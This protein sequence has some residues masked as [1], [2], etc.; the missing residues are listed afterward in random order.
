VHPQRA[1]EERRGRDRAELTRLYGATVRLAEAR[2]RRDADEEHLRELRREAA[3]LGA[4]VRSRHHHGAVHVGISHVIK[5]HPSPKFSNAQ[6]V[7]CQ[8]PLG[9][10]GL[11]VR[12]PPRRRTARWRITRRRWPNVRRPTTPIPSGLTGRTPSRRRLRWRRRCNKGAVLRRILGGDFY[13]EN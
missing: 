9:A 2:K 6:Y 13:E 5:P 11:R 12:P 4:E 3:E 7:S 8:Q 1:L 10:S